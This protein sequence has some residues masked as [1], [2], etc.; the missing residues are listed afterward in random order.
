MMF[1]RFGLTVCG[2]LLTIQPVMAQVYNR[3]DA[4]APSAESTWLE[5]LIG[6]GFMIGCLFVAFKSSKRT[7]LE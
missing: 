1:K 7:T 6:A 3:P 5:W 4:S 2:L